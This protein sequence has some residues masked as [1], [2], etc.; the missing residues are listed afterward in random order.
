MNM[1]EF[2][3]R[4]KPVK[5]I[6]ADFEFFM[7]N[8]KNFGALYPDSV[9]LNGFQTG[10]GRPW[11]TMSYQNIDL[12]SRQ[13]GFTGSVSW[14][15]TQNIVM[16]FFATWQKTTLYDVIP[17]SP[18]SAVSMMITDAYF[19]YM[20]TDSITFSKR[21]PD[22]RIDKEE[23]SS[24]PSVF[25]GFAV[26]IKMLDEKLTLHTDAYAYSSQTFANKN[27]TVEIDGKVILNV[28]LSYKLYRDNL[29]LFVNVRNLLG[30]KRE[31]AFMDE[32]GPQYLIGLNANF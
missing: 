28:R 11:V 13:L 9:N 26:S 27:G 4:V 14:V 15:A 8:A 19:N 31:F 25:G 2:G 29:S 21:F 12:T 17:I 16:K 23:N 7:I 32:I 30:K 22:D 18:D 24:T 5:S 1:L 20:R 6:Q 10:T 3:Y